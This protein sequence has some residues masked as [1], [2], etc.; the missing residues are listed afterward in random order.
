MALLDLHDES[1]LIVGGGAVALRRAKTL[2]DAGLR[3]RVVAP[4]IVAELLALP[5]QAEARGYQPGDLRGVR[6]VVAATSDAALNDRICAQARAA[7]LLVNHAG[8]AGRGTLRFPAVAARGGV[9]V[10]VASGGELP[11]LARALTRQFAAQL[12]PEPQVA[13]WH[14][15]REQ[16]LALPAEQRA[17]A[18][19]ALGQDIRRHVGGAA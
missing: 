12:P 3:V 18:L 2:L 1:A 10:A 16:A 19:G 15:A 17:A 4:E 5:V 11:L 7:G 14:S 6:L 13:A 8:D 9:Q